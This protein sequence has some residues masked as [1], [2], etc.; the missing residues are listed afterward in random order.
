VTLE[1]SDAERDFLAELLEAAHRARLRE[2]HHTATHDY[3]QYL[4]R[5]IETLEH[6]RARIGLPVQPP[7]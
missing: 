4:R 1:F 6:L 7:A 3:R 2:L 5:Q